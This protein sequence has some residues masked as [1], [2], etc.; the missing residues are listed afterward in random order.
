LPDSL[1]PLYAHLTQ[2]YPRISGKRYGV[3]NLGDSSYTS[4]NDAG[5][6]LDAAFADL[7]AHRLGEPLVLD[8]CSGDNPATLV[9]LWIH[10][11]APLL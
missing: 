1:I 3:I 6:M 7:G 5:R 4:F 2:D 10:N 11:W 8:A 9:N